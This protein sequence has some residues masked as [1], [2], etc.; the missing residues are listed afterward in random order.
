[1]IT[2]SQEKRGDKSHRQKK[3][4]KLSPNQTL[5]NVYSPA[6]QHSSLNLSTVFVLISM[7]GI[8]LFQCKNTFFFFF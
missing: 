8:G 6:P 7:P 2:Y 5:V 4:K 1:M 3:K